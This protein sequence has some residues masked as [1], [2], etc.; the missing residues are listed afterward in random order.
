MPDAACTGVPAGVTL[1]SCSGNLTASG[2]Y[3]SCLFSGT[4]TVSANNVTITR[5]KVSG[6]RVNAGYGNQTGLVLIDVE[7]DGGNRDSTAGIGEDNYTCI[8]CNVWRTGRG[9]NA[10]TNVVI[11]DS[12]FHDFYKTPDA[13][14]SGIGSNG[15]NNNQIIHNNIDCQETACS[16]AL[17]MYGDFEPIA[18]VLIQQNLFA[19]PGSYCTYAGSVSGKPYPNATNVRYLDNLW[20]KKYTPVCGMYGPVTSWAW[21]A[22]NVW[23]SGNRWQDGSGP[24]NP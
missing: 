15:G 7:I 23:N 22:G 6:G 17:V 10:G 20:S 4:V 24:V 2:T 18:N 14:M 11:R 8:R 12:W 16:G 21:N 9:A 3:D 5:S 19:S 13:H 1:H